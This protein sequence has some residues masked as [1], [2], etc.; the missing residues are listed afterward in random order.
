MPNELKYLEVIRIQSLWSAFP[1]IRLGLPEKSLTLIS[2]VLHIC[3]FS[4]GSQMSLLAS[5]SSVRRYP[6]AL[7]EQAMSTR[8]EDGRYSATDLPP[9]SRLRESEGPG[10]SMGSTMVNL[11]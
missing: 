9:T 11:G 6:L 8:V 2:S 1:A 4:P 7:V 10:R 3:G 5:C